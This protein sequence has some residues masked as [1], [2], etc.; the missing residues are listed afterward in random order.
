MRIINAYKNNIPAI[1]A[2]KSKYISRNHSIMCTQISGI[3]QLIKQNGVNAYVILLLCVYRAIDVFMLLL[4]LYIS[5]NVKK[6]KKN[7]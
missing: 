6:E 3:T 1:V 4:F 5:F 2:T 7:N